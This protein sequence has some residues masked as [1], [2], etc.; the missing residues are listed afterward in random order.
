MVMAETDNAANN[1]FGGDHPR[2][3]GPVYKGRIGQRALQEIMDI[4]A[5]DPDRPGLSMVAVGEANQSADVDRH[6]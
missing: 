3:G 4:R 6:N 2:S 1:T 5:P